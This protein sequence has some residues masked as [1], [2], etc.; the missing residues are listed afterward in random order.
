MKR[1]TAIA[2]VLLCLP[3]LVDA[4]GSGPGDALPP[5]RVPGSRVVNIR[6]ETGGLAAYYSIPSSSVFSTHGGRNRPCAYTARASG[7]TSDGRAVQAGQVVE[8][9]RWIFREGTVPSFEEPNPAAPTTRGPLA[10]ARRSFVVFCDVY[11]ATTSIGFI[12]VTSRDPMLDPRPQLTNLYNQLQLVRPTVYRNAVVDT[13]GG[14]ITRFPAWLAIG[15]EAWAAG[16]SNPAYYRGWTLYLLTSP[17]SLDFH[18]TF[19]PDP[20]RPSTPFSGIVGCV[21]AGTNPTSAAGVL[22]ALPAL[23][24]QTRPGVNGPC[25]WTP[26]GPG[27]VTIQARITHSVTLWA[28]GYTEPQPDYVWTSFP[29]TFSTGE[30]SV[31]NV[32][33]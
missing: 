18:V 12:Q 20:E 15:P 6:N 19:T 32:I 8:S 16:R 9:M 11:S 10:S 30:L 33:D 1:A 26:P 3:T 21:P 2:L 14:L 31:V 7:R 23:P 27:G 28:N 17:K 22:P 24:E 29:V 5:L 13:W 25:M 4:A